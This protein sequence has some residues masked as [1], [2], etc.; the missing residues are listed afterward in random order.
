M[1]D[2]YI[3]CVNY[4]FVINKRYS[5]VPILHIDKVEDLML[6]DSNEKEKAQGVVNIIGN[7]FLE[8]K[9]SYFFISL[10]QLE[11]I[12]K[13]IEIANKSLPKPKRDNSVEENNKILE[14]KIHSFKSI[15]NKI[16]KF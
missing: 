4:S 2:K 3:I 12:K 16:L 13:E 15:F 7:M 6:F 5:L 1:E 10:K 11:E 8:S 14:K 9:V